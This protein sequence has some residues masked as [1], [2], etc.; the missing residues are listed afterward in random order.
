MNWA[1]FLHADVNSGKLK[2]NIFL[3]GRDQK[4]VW[5]S[6]FWMTG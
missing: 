3:G 4:W 1:D 2:N 6:N 5:D